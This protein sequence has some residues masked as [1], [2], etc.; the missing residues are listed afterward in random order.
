M[1]S[2][3]LCY[4]Y[5][6]MQAKSKSDFFSI[7]V[8]A[9]NE[10]S[11][12]KASITEVL[13]YLD[14]NNLNAEVLVV[15]A[16]GTDNTAAIIK[17]M[18]QND[19]RIK[20]ITHASRVGKGRDVQSGVLAAKGSKIIFTDADLAT[21]VHHLLPMLELLD[22]SEVVVGVRDINRMHKDLKRRATSKLS[23][24]AVSVLAVSGIADTQ[25][26]FKGFQAP[27][28]H[29]LFY[30]QKNMGWGFDFEI[31]ALA[32]KLKF[33]IAQIQIPDWHDP[34]GENGL[35]GDSQLKAMASS[36]KELLA[37]RANMATKRYK[38]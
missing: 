21:P 18:S 2:L 20:L 38:L 33:N 6:R 29:K 19:K 37:L 15:A 11:L 28:A 27:A 4:N 1:A 10:A 9:F 16:K 34:K 7:I 17:K 13:A 26:G 35:A 23:H 30:L 5:T 24:A 14:T 32:K 31:L 36:L 8:P 12:I 25:C 22:S 3:W